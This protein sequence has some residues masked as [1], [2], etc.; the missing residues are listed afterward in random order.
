MSEWRP[1]ET[2]PE[3]EHIMLF[4]PGGERGNGGIECATIFRDETGA[5]SYWT[6]GGPNAGSDWEPRD[7]ERPTHW[8][9]LPEQPHD[10]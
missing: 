7:G 1:I 10:R 3:G 8:R 2:A 4:W 6:H 9:R 5:L